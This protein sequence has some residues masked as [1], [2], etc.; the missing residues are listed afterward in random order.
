MLAWPHPY[1]NKKQPKIRT[2]NSKLNR[3]WKQMKPINSAHVQNFENV[4]TA[5][6]D[7]F[8]Q[9]DYSHIWIYHHNGG[10]T[11]EWFRWDFL[12]AYRS[13]TMSLFDF[14]AISNCTSMQQTEKYDK[15]ICSKGKKSIFFVSFVQ[16]YCDSSSSLDA[17]VCILTA[18][19]YTTKTVTEKDWKN[20]EHTEIK[21]ERGKNGMLQLNMNSFNLTP[22]N[23]IKRNGQTFVGLWNSFLCRWWVMSTM[24]CFHVWIHSVVVR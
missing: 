14:C 3:Q 17:F 4:Q 20:K 6:H 24:G 16:C 9:R 13:S 21:R 22:C 18:A 10:K 5:A 23:Y 8:L 1:R 12:A 19:L 7:N 2:I 11:L 15:L